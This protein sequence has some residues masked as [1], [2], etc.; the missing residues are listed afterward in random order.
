MD[1]QRSALPDKKA[2]ELLGYRLTGAARLHFIAFSLSI[3]TVLSVALIQ[4]Y[5][6]NLLLPISV[7]LV[8]IFILRE[9]HASHVHMLW[10][11]F[12]LIT[13]CGIGIY[14]V[15]YQSDLVHMSP[16]GIIEVR[17]A[18]VRGPL[19][20]ALK[21]YLETS[22]DIIFEIAL[23]SVLLGAVVVPQIF[24]FLLSGLFGC[25]T[26][27]I[28]VSRATQIA[29]LWLIKLFCGL[30]ALELSAALFKIYKFP[31]SITGW[32]TINATGFVNPNIKLQNQHAFNSVWSLMAC[33][34]LSV[35]YYMGHEIFDVLE[36][37]IRK[38]KFLREVRAYMTRFKRSPNLTVARPAG[39][40]RLVAGVEIALGDVVVRVMPGIEMDFLS[41]VLR[42]VKSAMVVPAGV[43]PEPNRQ[44]ADQPSDFYL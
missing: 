8:A 38:I 35:Y 33:F 9:D 24:S 37:R 7:I 19:V 27:P 4:I 26:P 28:L 41:A 36:K 29:F 30:A 13:Y 43:H 32:A 42:A 15:L 2:I 25:G 44:A 18:G 39:G 11:L 3:T 10:Y 21:W 22:V 6:V 20:R 5:P 1:E 34:L 16:N 23:L 14:H 12:F 31:E 17:S 40:V